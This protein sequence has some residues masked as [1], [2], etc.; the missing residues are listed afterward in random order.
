[1][2]PSGPE[3]GSEVRKTVTIVFCDVVGSTAMGESLD[4]EAVR[5]VLA[6]YFE[7]MREA[8]ERHGGTVEKFI[9]DAVMAVFGVPEVHED[10]ALRAVRAA[11]E[12]R[13]RLRALNKELERDFGIELENRMGVNTGEVVAGAGTQSLATG[14]AV[15]LAARLEQA[16]GPGEILLGEVTHRLVRDA[17]DAE[18]VEP[19]TVRGKAEP[20]RAFRMVGVIGTQGV[21]RR[22]DTPMVGRARELRLLREALDRAVS[23]RTSVLFTVLGA[24]GAGKSRLTEEFLGSLDGARVL[25]GRCLPYGDGITYWPVV[26]I[27]TQA[28]ELTGVEPPEAVRAKLS[29]LLGSDSPAVGQLGQLLGVEG[30]DALPDETNR[31]VRSLL[32]AMARTVPLVVE[33]DDLQFAEPALLELVEYVADWSRGAPLLLLCSARHDLLDLR[34]DWGGGKLNATTIHLEPL[35]EEETRLV[36]ANVAGGSLPEPVANRVATA[37]E[38]NPLFAEQF[39]GMLLDQGAL[40]RGPDGEI[41][42]TAPEGAGAMQVPGSISALLDARIERLPNPERAVL[43]RASIEGKVFH[44]GGVLALT[45]DGDRAATDRLLMSLVRRD[46]VRPDESQ[47]AGDDG[48]RF[49]NLLIR[50]AAYARTPKERRAEM[51]ERFAEWLEEAAGER[52]REL[53][54]IVGYH[55]EQAW[56]LR[57]QLGPLDEHGTTLGAR[58]ARMLGAAGS[59]AQARGDHAGAGILLQRA[60]DAMPSEDPYRPALLTDLARSVGELGDYRRAIQVAEDAARLAE[61]TGDRRSAAMAAVWQALFHRESFREGARV[62]EGAIAELEALGDRAAVARALSVLGPLQ[63]WDG[64]VA[65]ATETLSRAADLARDAG[66]RAMEAEAVGT[67]ASAMQT[68]PTPVEEALRRIAEY[69]RRLGD[70][71]TAQAFL[72]H[73]QAQLFALVGRVADARASFAASQRMW[74]E[75]GRF[76]VRAAGVM[77]AAEIE[78]VSGKPADGIEPVLEAIQVLESGGETGWRSTLYGYLAELRLGTDDLQGAEEAARSCRELAGGDD[79][80]AQMQWRVALAKVEIR[81]GRPEGGERLA[82]EA[83]EIIG[84]TEYPV[85]Q[86]HGLLALALALHAQGREEESRAAARD[87]MAR[88]ESK[89][90]TAWLSR[91]RELFPEA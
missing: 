47:F 21:A 77:V 86:G 76:A 88:Y 60:A 14:D 9:G 79:W 73:V 90:A 58:A 44:R 46:L 4:A 57:A 32:E 69:G 49:R 20:V 71:I 19:L 17:V 36:A 66:D 55:L 34:A 87:A 78:L 26:E 12:M 15:N 3:A 59:R 91:A 40:A 68:G 65:L 64:K 13:D 61:V 81:R 70:V 63:I 80:L 67:I 84:R 39:V 37:A 10:D 56:R 16:A 35:S 7:Q 33:V 89:G 11:A 42:A 23:D 6:R 41:V 51:H 8:L 22:F 29:A 74:A 82:R 43:G 2:E 50:D 31:A 27:L 75:L 54:E 24:P 48:F 72:H 62:V 38:G 1:M 45:P 52:A 5:R 83:V 53:D 25:R 85:S 30:A 28:A 18:P